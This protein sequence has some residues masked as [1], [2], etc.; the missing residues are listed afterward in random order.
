MLQ[1]V[2]Q[3]ATVFS[4]C[5]AP[6]AEPAL[7]LHVLPRGWRLSWQ[8]SKEAGSAAGCWLEAPDNSNAADSPM[9]RNRS[10]SATTRQGD[11]QPEGQ[12]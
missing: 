12:D 8:L 2:Q 5:H 9:A 1:T 11:L 4:L 7:L 3:P 10:G 6:V